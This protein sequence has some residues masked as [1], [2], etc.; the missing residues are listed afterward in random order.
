MTGKSKGSLQKGRY[1]L[2]AEE[3]KNVIWENFLSLNIKEARNH[4]SNY[5]SVAAGP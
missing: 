4:N 5:I 2:Q 3:K 1:A